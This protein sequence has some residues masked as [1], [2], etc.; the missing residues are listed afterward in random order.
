MVYSFIVGQQ[1]LRAAAGLSG[2]S[3]NRS[4]SLRKQGVSAGSDD[5]P[6][7]SGGR[8]TYSSGH[9]DGMSASAVALQPKP[10]DVSGSVDRVVSSGTGTSLSNSRPKK[11]RCRC[12]RK[13]MS[14]LSTTTRRSSKIAPA[15]PSL[16]C[17]GISLS[18]WVRTYAS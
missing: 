10:R 17:A 8:Q 13:M 2:E 14:L 9:S 6:K 7:G 5:R 3:R 4:T 1:D 16:N 15:T 18:Q 12:S 11:S